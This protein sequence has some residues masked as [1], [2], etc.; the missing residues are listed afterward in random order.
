MFSLGGQLG[1]KLPKTLVVL[2]GRVSVI[3]CSARVDRLNALAFL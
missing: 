2:E 3:V 1:S